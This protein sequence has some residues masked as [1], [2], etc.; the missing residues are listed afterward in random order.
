MS[1]H[2]EAAN[3]IMAIT[4]G[5]LHIAPMAIK[6]RAKLFAGDSQGGGLVLRPAPLSKVKL[7][8]AVNQIVDTRKLVQHVIMQA[9]SNLTSPKELDIVTHRHVLV[10]LFLFKNLITRQA[11]K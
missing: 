9:D 4:V 2:E 5:N 10:C 8:C 11:F 6:S 7:A 3:A 1:S